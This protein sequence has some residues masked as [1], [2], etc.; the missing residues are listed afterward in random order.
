MVASYGG[1]PATDAQ[2]LAQAKLLL[3]PGWRERM[4]SFAYLG[5]TWQEFKDKLKTELE[6]HFPVLCRSWQTLLVIPREAGRA[7]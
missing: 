3:E 5:E 1:V 2:L 4:D 7:Q 6:I